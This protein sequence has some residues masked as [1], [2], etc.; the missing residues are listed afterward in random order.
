MWHETERELREQVE[1]YD[2]C[3]LEG[4]PEDLRRFLHPDAVFTGPNFERLAEGVDACVQ[5]Y[6]AFLAEAK[7]HDFKASDYVIDVADDSAI[8]TYRWTIDYQL[9]DTRSRESG[10]E[11]LVWV[12]RRGKWLIAWRTQRPEPAS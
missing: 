11:L 6:V 4:R 10:Q 5:S 12:G 9:G 1:S 2:R 8:M 7:V 3:W